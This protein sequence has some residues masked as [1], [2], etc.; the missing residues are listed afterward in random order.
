MAGAGATVAGYSDREEV[1]ALDID[2]VR[3]GD[4]SCTGPWH[5]NPRMMNW[6]AEVIARQRNS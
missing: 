5:R 2:A 3:E 4:T 6:S 1:V